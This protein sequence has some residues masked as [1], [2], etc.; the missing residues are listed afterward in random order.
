MFTVDARSCGSVSKLACHLRKMSKTVV[1][2]VPPVY[3][4]CND[5]MAELSVWR[6]DNQ[7]RPAIR[8]KDF[9]D[10]CQLKVATLKLK[11]RFD[12]LQKLERKRKAVANALHRAGDVTLMV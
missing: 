12:N 8:W 3:Q 4:V 2:R 7:N 11:T 6:A 1:Q 5:L 10:L 9:C